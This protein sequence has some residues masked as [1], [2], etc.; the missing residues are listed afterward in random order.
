[1]TSS[2][3]IAKWR[4]TFLQ[5]VD[6]NLCC[7]YY[8]RRWLLAALCHI[9]FAISFGLRCNF[10]A[11]KVIMFGNFT[12]EAEHDLAHLHAHGSAIAV[13]ES[14][15][16]YGCCISVLPA[17]ILAAK[18]SSVRL[19]GYGIGLLATLNLLL[20]WAFRSGFVAPVL[21]QFT[22][23]IAQGLLYPCML[24]IWSIWAPLS[25]KSKLATISVTG[26]YV[27]VFVGMPL[28]ALMVSHF[29]F[30]GICGLIWYALWSLFAVGKPSEHPTLRDKEKELILRGRQ[31]N[32]ATNTLFKMKKVPWRAI[33]SS[34]PVWAIIV[35]TFSRCW[36]MYTLINDQLTFMSDTLG[37]SM[38]AVLSAIL[39]SI[40]HGLMSITV[41]GSGML[42]DCLRN[43][44]KFATTTVRKISHCTGCGLEAT[45]LLLCAFVKDK[46]LAVTFLILA[47]GCS[48]LAVS[49]SNINHLD[50][51]QRY[52]TILTGIC[53]TFGYSAGILTPLV[54]ENVLAA[55]GIDGWKIAFSLAAVIHTI[56]VLFYGLF[57]S[58]EIQPW[59]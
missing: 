21:I 16:F 54:T 33:L 5:I 55:A 24:G 31:S 13:M 29:G 20:P 26:N 6:E 25:E 53:Q 50:L 2:K 58:G 34:L 9:G 28:S 46:T 59:G 52:A 41:I 27:G 37:F 19:L 47:R 57:A 56:S 36:M 4:Q 22:Q 44:Y 51:T 18:Y 43:R 8:S 38:D 15:F 32:D 49:G 39:A 12:N 45:F 23:G 42:A 35:A 30:S 3:G 48:G 11:A 1:M 14:S 10:G 7:T 17:G 40:P